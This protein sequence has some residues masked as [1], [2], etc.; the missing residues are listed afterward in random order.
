MK[1]SGLATVTGMPGQPALGHR[2][3]E[4]A[5]PEPAAD[6]PGQLVGHHVPGVV[7]VTGVA[8]PGIAE[9][10]DQPAFIRHARSRPAAARPAAVARTT[11]RPPQ[12]GPWPAVAGPYSLARRGRTASRPLRS[13][14][15]HRGRLGRRRGR[16]LG[17]ADLGF[18]LL[19][20]GRGD[21]V[22]HQDLGLHGQ[23]RARRQL[24]VARVHRGAD[25]HVLHA[26]LDA[27]RDV[28]GLGLD[29]D[30][31][32][33]L[34]EQAAGEHLAGDLDRDVHGDLLT[35]ADQDQVHVLDGAPD[36][37]P[38]HRLGQ[39]QLVPAGQAIQPDQHVGGLQRHHHVVA[40]QRDV[41][42]VGAV[43]IQHG[44]HPAVPRAHGG[45]GPC[46]TRCAAQPRCGPRARYLLL[47]GG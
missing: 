2:G 3:P 26:D 46:R 39:H 10:G 4:L 25:L 28:R 27:R 41:P 12:P 14:S 15:R 24:Q 11:P 33:L 16:S 35:A 42:G 23:R 22:Q 43:A 31:D 36:R 17:R 38:L 13:P 29:R 34:V 5:R 32:Q 18:Q 44:G 40:G 30:L 7:P 37:V 47:H 45:R 1:V 8:G 21:D 6:P 20:G 19:G 9:P